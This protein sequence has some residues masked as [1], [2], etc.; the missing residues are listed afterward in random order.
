MFEKGIQDAHNGRKP[1]PYDGGDK[2]IQ[3][4]RFFIFD[5]ESF[6]F[7][8]QANTKKP[9]W[10]PEENEVR[11]E[12]MNAL[13]HTGGFTDAGLKKQITVDMSAPVVGGKIF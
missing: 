5:V 12:V 10:S 2:R 7:H 8:Y 1:W 6:H 4:C 9:E 3:R 13:D 11:G